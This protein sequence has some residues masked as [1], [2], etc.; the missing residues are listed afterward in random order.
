MKNIKKQDIHIRSILQMIKHQPKTLSQIEEENWLSKIKNITY[1]SNF[2]PSS[3]NLLLIAKEA[4]LTG[5]VEILSFFERKYHF[6]TDNDIFGKL[7]AKNGNL[8][9]F[10]HFSKYFEKMNDWKKT[11]ILQKAIDND[12]PHILVNF[13]QN[14]SIVNQHCLDEL[15]ASCEMRFILSKKS[16][17]WEE[18]LQLITNEIE[19]FN[20]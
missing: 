7:I 20:D 9:S 15:M 16:N 18:V 1:Y 13:F 11:Q 14:G 5:N 10:I 3:Q 8:K 17:E 19:F 2:V 6:S 12:N 4:Y